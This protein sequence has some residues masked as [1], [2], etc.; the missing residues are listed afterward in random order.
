MNDAHTNRVGAARRG[1]AA[2]ELAILLPFLGLMFAAALDFARIFCATQTLN[3]CAYAAALYASGTSTGD[4]STAAANAAVADGT[5]LN[6]PLQPEKVAVTVAGG[7]ATATVDYDFQLLTPLP[8][9]LG[10]VHLQ[11][12]ATLNVA[13]VPG[14]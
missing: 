14:N 2:T 3:E 5:T 7:V 8:G 12:T 9:Y 6:P 1:A 4:V 10:V 13:P 11:R